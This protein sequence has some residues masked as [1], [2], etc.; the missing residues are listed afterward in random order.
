M[1]P[2]TEAQR[3]AVLINNTL[4]EDISKADK[5]LTIKK[6][7]ADSDYSKFSCVWFTIEECGYPDWT[8]DRLYQMHIYKNQTGTQY[9]CIEI[10]RNFKKGRHNLMFGKQRGMYG[11][12]SYDSDI[13]LRDNR[14]DP[15]G[16]RLQN[17]FSNAF[18]RIER[19]AGERLKCVRTNPSE[20]NKILCIPYG[21]T[22][23]N[24]GEENLIRHLQR[25]NFKKEFLASI[26][27]AKKHGFVFTE[28][29]SYEWFDMVYCLIKTKN[30]NHNPKYV[31][32]SNLNEMHN[33]FLKKY[34]AWQK[35]KEEQ[36]AERAMARREKEQLAMLES[37]RK[38]N[39]DYIKRRRRFF[40]LLISDSKFDIHVLK[41]VNEFF[42]EGTAMHHC[43]FSMK[44]YKEPDSLIMSCRDKQG[45]R[46]ET[47]EVDLR[48]FKIAQCYGKYDQ[49]TE[50][51]NHILRLVN[52][53]MNKI[54]MCQNSRYKA[55][56]KTN[57]LQ[58]A[59]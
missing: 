37:E 54:R 45:N 15:W 9:L 56:E 11:L 12:F 10:L 23:Y 25:H 36:A 20:L 19:Q 39:E 47:I 5:E 33:Y 13:E 31:A 53:N 55:K 30:D 50:H 35:K 21:E 51:H 40:D 58:I 46:V 6:I 42:E 43:V 8:I 38:V 22:L 1:K 59:I 7:E 3:E 2:K 17:V 26:R 28:E 27:I 18:F 32:P 48:T 57:N 34:Q 52:K 41:D 14:R 16:Y 4:L 44:Y 24:A 49:F 29:N